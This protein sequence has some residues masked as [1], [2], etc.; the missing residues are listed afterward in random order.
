MGA[1]S[2]VD[3]LGVQA[4][5]LGLSTATHVVR[6]GANVVIDDDVEVASPPVYDERDLERPDGARIRVR[7]AGHGP[8]VVL[9]HG[10]GLGASSWNPVAVRLVDSGHRVV[11]F[12][13]RAHGSSGAGDDLVTT[14]ALQGD[15]V[16]V[17]EELEV[18]DAVLVGHS[19]GGYVAMA[20]LVEQPEVQERLRGLVLVA[21]LA[22]DLLHESPDRGGRRRLRS[23]IVDRVVRNET[24]RLLL[25]GFVDG[26]GVS[27][28]VSR[29]FLDEFANADHG[30][31]VSLLT[32][33]AGR[34]YYGRLDGIAVPTVVVCGDDDRVTPPEHSDAIA[35]EIPD[36]RRVRIQG[37]GHLLTWQHPGRIDRAIV[38]LTPSDE[39]AADTPTRRAVLILNPA[40]GR[41][42][43]DET[44]D[45]VVDVLARAGVEAEVRRTEG[46]GDARRWASEAAHDDEV[47]L[48]VAAG[49]DGT[50]R[51]VA[52]GLV[53]A[54]RR[55]R[56]GVI[57][58]GTANMLARFLDIP[59]DDVATAAACAANRGDRELD[60]L[61]L[62]DRDEYAM[63]MVD[64]GFD[65]DLVRHADRRL[66]NL[67]GSLAYVVSGLRNTVGLREV[68]IRLSL[69]GESHD[70]RGHSVLCLNA[71]RI[72][73]V[74]IADEIQP[75][76]GLVH[77]GVVR[78]PGPLRVLWTAAGMV[79]AGRDAHPNVDWYEATSVR[80]ETD[81]PLPVQVDGDAMDDTPLELELLPRALT[82][83]VPGDA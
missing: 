36:A 34:S 63:L 60:V 69:D 23:G 75:D 61:H 73:R 53:E 82:V 27:P 35:D 30:A 44:E 83:A 54:S 40:S 42:D 10:Y 6:L 16:A 26:I 18:E 15:L 32:E 9:L 46:E 41:H 59:V 12:D 67:L 38:S 4:A 79:L 51:E 72:D 78:G 66:K 29:E 55:V 33:L 80:V 17:L 74:T 50:V 71:G 48:V 76:D 62:V 49:G 70:V 2:T 3:R 25:A 52:S 19:T 13:W 7:V 37:A 43:A 1:R 8:T 45:T 56:L 21:T 5:R 20:T 64:A 77:V 22:G 65:G 57:P 31:L 28:A 81:E 11:S 47:D 68:D 14:D 39:D 58:M 24:L